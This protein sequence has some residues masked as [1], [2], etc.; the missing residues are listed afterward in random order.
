MYVSMDKFCELNF[1]SYAYITVQ[2][3]YLK[4]SE[5]Y[6]SAF[7]LSVFGRVNK[8]LFPTTESCVFNNLVAFM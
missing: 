5:Q 2:T 4:D 3:F 6:F 1:S 7:N 8:N